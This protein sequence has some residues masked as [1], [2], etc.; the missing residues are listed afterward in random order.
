MTIDVELDVI[1]LERSRLEFRIK[2]IREGMRFQM[3][4]F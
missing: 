3:P 4:F 1:E 2:K